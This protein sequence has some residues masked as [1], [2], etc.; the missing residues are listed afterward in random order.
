MRRLLLAALLASVSAI[1]HA[2]DD[3]SPRIVV[4]ANGRSTLPPDRADIAYTVRGEGATSDEAVRQLV[5]KRDAI[6]RGLA[7]FSPRPEAHATQVNVNDVR[8][9]DCQRYGAPSLSVGECAIQGYTAEL[10]LSI[11][12]AS[13]KDAGTMVGLIGRLGGTN[14]R[15]ERFFLSDLGEAQNRATA[16]ALVLARRQAEAVAAGAH[17]RLGP[18]LLVSNNGEGEARFAETVRTPFVAPPAPPPPP[19][20]PPPIA[21]TLSPQPIDTEARVTVAFAILP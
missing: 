13:V 11:R 16:A 5:S 7:T 17:V 2:A 19:P 15:V 8:G 3:Q 20:P 1:A 14:P 18:V 10:S 12:T 4:S 9:R 21:V 6:E